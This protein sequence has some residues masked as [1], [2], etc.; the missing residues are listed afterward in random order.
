MTLPLSN[1][2]N[3]YVGNGAVNSYNY[4]F[5]LFVA[6]ELRVIVSDASDVAFPDLVLGVD[7]SLTGVGNA[8]GGAVNLIDIGQA[9]LTG[10]NLTNGYKIAILGNMPIAQN[11][12]I[13]NQGAYFPNVIE[14]RFDII[15]ASQQE[16]SE[17]LSRA[18][19]TIAGLPGSGFSLGAPDPLK[20]LRWNAGGTAIESADPTSSFTPVSGEA[21]AGAIDGANVNFTIANSPRA[22]SF[23]LFKN[24]LR[25]PAAAFTLVGTALTMASAPLAF[26]ELLCDYEY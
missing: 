6:S 13:R 22:G 19:L 3:D 2:R 8:A 16:I 4:T 15:S 7:Y 10:G 23:K 17:K 18:I 25:Q 1:R 26:E 20:F 12:S 5:K 11:T 14:D 9:W 24:G 21:P